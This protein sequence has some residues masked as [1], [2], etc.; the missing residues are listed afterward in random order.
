MARIGQCSRT[1]NRSLATIAAL[2]VQGV[3]PPSYA[4]ALQRALYRLFTGAS[5]SPHG[6][7]PQTVLTPPLPTSCNPGVPS[8]KR[9]EHPPKSCPALFPNRKVGRDNLHLRPNGHC[10]FARI[11]SQSPR[12]EN[13]I[14]KKIARQNTPV[15]PQISAVI[16]EGDEGLVLAVCSV[17]PLRVVTSHAL[18]RAVRKNPRN[19][20]AGPSPAPHRV[21]PMCSLNHGALPP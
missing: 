10:V 13:G 3:H 5:P 1:G 7:G 15:S 8:E 9:A 18:Y 19:R 17:V 2:L 20:I 6:L 14:P 4:V 16:T 11:D 21:D 12:D